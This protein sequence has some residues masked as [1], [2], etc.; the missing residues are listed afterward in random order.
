MNLLLELLVLRHQLLEL[1]FHLVK[2]LVGMCIV[3]LFF[4][5]WFSFS[6]IVLVN[7][8]LLEKLFHLLNVGLAELLCTL[9]W[10]LLCIAIAF[11]ALVFAF[12]S[13][14]LRLQSILLL[15]LLEMP[16]LL[17][18][19]SASLLPKPCFKGSCSFHISDLF[20]LHFSQSLMQL[21]LS[22]M[23]IWMALCSLFMMR[24]FMMLNNAVVMTLVLPSTRVRHMMKWMAFSTSMFLS[25]L[26][27]RL[28]WVISGRSFVYVIYC[29]IYCLLH[30]FLRLLFDFTFMLVV[31][32]FRVLQLMFHF[33]HHWVIKRS[34]FSPIALEISHNTWGI[35]FTLHFV[36]RLMCNSLLFLFEV[37]CKSF[38]LF[39][40]FSF[41][42]SYFWMFRLML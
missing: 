27:F 19:L 42:V 25:F 5:L 41:F 40:K 38:L 36:K 39:H 15:K 1:R 3:L 4:M 24:R 7:I 26:V 6:L 29:V 11:R 20:D 14:M 28:L 33:L 34:C 9:C 22:Q 12:P 18:L 30:R 10:F 21:A 32:I 13:S 2:V 17:L 23:S 16:E 31:F 35:M 37:F 8:G